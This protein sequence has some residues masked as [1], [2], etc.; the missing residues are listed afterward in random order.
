M[1]LQST[2]MS[3]VVETRF[4]CLLTVLYLCLVDLPSA[5]ITYSISEEAN[6][7]A[8]VG[9]IA[10]DFNLNTEDLQSRDFQIV[11]SS[12][13]KFFKV[14]MKTGA[15]IVNDR[16]DREELC[17][18]NENCVLNLEAIVKHP[19]NLYRFEVNVLDIN[20]NSPLFNDERLFLNITEDAPVGDRYFLPNAVDMDVGSNSVKTYSLASNEHFSLDMQ[21][22]REVISA[23]LVLQKSL[24]R[25]RESQINIILYAVDGGKPPKS[26]TLQITVNVQD[27]NDNKPLFSK[28][29]YKARVDEHARIGSSVITV[30]ATDPDEGSNGEIRYSF[31]GHN[32]QHAG[33]FSINAESGAITVNGQLDHEEH[34]AVE[35]RVQAT[36]KGAS[37]KSTY[38]KVLVEITDV[39]DNA[40]VILVTPLSE[41]VREDSERGTAV[42]LV[43]VSDQDRGKN[44]VVQ[45]SI[46]GSSDFQLNPSYKNH[47]SLEVNGPLDRERTSLYNITIKATDEGV[48][49]LSSTTMLTIHISDMNDNAPQ[50]AERWI[51]IYVKENSPVG[52]AIATVTAHDSDLG[53]NAKV[54]YS[55]AETKNE[56]RLASKFLNLNA[57]TGE[58][59]SAQTF[60]YEEM[61]TFQFQLEARDSGEPPMSSNVTVTVF[62]LDDN[63]NSPVILPPYSDQGSVNSENIPYSAEAGYFVAK[64]RAVDADSGYNALLS[65]HITEPKGTNLFRIGTSSGEIRTKR[66]MSDSDLKT[67]PLVVTVSDHGEP[68]LSATV[69]IDIVVVESEA[70]VQKP[71]R[72][73]P[74]QD[75]ALST[76]NMYLFIAI[77]SVSAI[78][79]VSLVTLMAVK[80]HRTD[81]IFSSC[82]APMVTTHPDGSWAYSKTTQQY[83]V[84]FSSDTLKSDVVVF[85]SPF[86]PADA[87]LIS[88][89]GGDTFR[90]TQT[91]P[92]TTKTVYSVTEEVN[93]G[94][95]IG[96][97]AKDL[98]LNVQELESRMFQIVPGTYSQYFK[99]DVC[100]SSDTLKS[101][102]IVLP[103]PFA[104]GEGDLIS[105]DGG[106][107]CK[108]TQTL[109]TPQK[110][111]DVIETF[112]MIYC[113]CGVLQEAQTVGELVLQCF[114]CIV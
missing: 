77:V 69:S 94:T 82:S 1:A 89:D 17:G 90:Q 93:T 64:I 46:A 18:V 113:C 8:A 67:H 44:G 86:P 55:F 36:D 70:D 11:S 51:R 76:I 59:H 35:L 32:A 106:D 65:Y 47:Y 2:A 114:L 80:C 105:I 72:F 61:K 87:E 58:I 88:I 48:P 13:K 96:N 21:N 54:T 52:S 26:G 101:D 103:S 97:V 110:V 108:R 7:G 95:V 16:I 111:C 34:S 37:P 112:Q 100:F 68:N 12:N 78:F 31:I 57:L 107:T 109:P 41:S 66:R 56:G 42:A 84:C 102:V 28:S 73:V 75:E 9:N 29:L 33:M 74:V 62:V 5:Q 79:L 53:E 99:Y 6:K 63:D 20:D 40:P 92:S 24:D 83:D 23:E 50:F 60:N 27:I 38:C 104:P 43:A 71:L 85:P 81:G 30:S 25:E 91:L 22:D 15:L 39:N 10:K 49:P 3:P 45:C 98:N 4:Y 19:V 14:N